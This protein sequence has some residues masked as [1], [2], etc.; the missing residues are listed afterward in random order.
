MP[1]RSAGPSQPGLGVWVAAER[2]VAA[3]RHAVPGQGHGVSALSHVVQTDA[4]AAQRLGLR[5]GGAAVHR[6]VQDRRELVVGAEQFVVVQS[7]AG[8][9]QGDRVQIVHHR[10]HGGLGQEHLAGGLLQGAGFDDVTVRRGQDPLVEE[11]PAL[12]GPV[13]GGARL[14][15]RGCQQG[16]RLRGAID[17]TQQIGAVGPQLAGGRGVRVGLGALQK[18]K[19]LVELARA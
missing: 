12:H 11:H 16:R 9:G 15:Q 13:P 7:G 3:A 17:A 14:G 2:E 18:T 6:A 19:G 1:R 4:Q 10:A 8:Q 5:V